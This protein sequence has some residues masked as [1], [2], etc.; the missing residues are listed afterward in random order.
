MKKAYYE[1]C[2]KPNIINE[3]KCY[4]QV[5]SS[6]LEQVMRISNKTS[7]K[8]N[9]RIGALWSKYLVTDYDAYK[10]VIENERSVLESAEKVLKSQKNSNEFAKNV[11]DL[12]VGSLK[13][14]LLP[15]LHGDARKKIKEE[16]LLNIFST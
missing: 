13:Q 5:T 9:D 6:I 2:F 8:P 14:Y 12:K 11:Q 7:P 1:Y 10:T 4:D 3:K 16:N 15:K